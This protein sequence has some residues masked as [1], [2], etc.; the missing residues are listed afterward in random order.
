MN[1]LLYFRLMWGAGLCILLS[2]CTRPAILPQ[3]VAAYFPAPTLLREGVAQ[4]YYFHYQRPGHSET[5]TDI[6]YLSY[7]WNDAQELVITNYRT[8]LTPNRMRRVTFEEGQMKTLEDVQYNGTDTLRKTLLQ[9]VMRNWQSDTAT[10]VKTSTEGIFL[11]RSVERQL[12]RRDTLV[13]NRPAIL[14]SGVYESVRI[15]DSDTLRFSSAFSEIY[16]EGIGLYGQ[17]FQ[18]DRYQGSLELIEQMTLQEFK[19]RQQHG[20]E[21]AAFIDPATVLG[22]R[23]DFK[24]CTRT[25]DIIDYYNPD[26]D[27]HY[28]GGKYAL[29]KAIKPQLK[30]EL[31]KGASGYLT[32]RFVINCEGEAGR[33]ILE[34]ADLDFQPTSFPKATVAHLGKI[35]AGLTDWPPVQ[36]RGEPADAYAYLTYK[37]QEG[38]QIELLP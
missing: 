24:L 5:W 38:E 3:P 36:L 25:E 9:P 16:A 34:T 28:R 18:S 4:K 23:P 17:A 11:D 7:Q 2:Q 30:T 26:P 33:F 29:W 8:D 13:E 21:R 32:F 20:L 35:T 31:L 22:Y 37:I 19:R 1:N 6:N 10:S 15:S 12:Q 14:F 27:I